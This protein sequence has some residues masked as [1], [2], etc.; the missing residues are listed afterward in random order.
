MNTSLIPEQ[1]HH[2]IPWVEKYGLE[3]DGYRDDLIYHSSTDD[4]IKMTE[5]FSEQ[6]AEILN[7]W[8]TDSELLKKPNTEYLMFS[9]FFMAY[10]YAMALLQSRKS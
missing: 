9:A 1:L 8:L 5:Q 4:L 6:D 2:L 10:E 7:S 3:D